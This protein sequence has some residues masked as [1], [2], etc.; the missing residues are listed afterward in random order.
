MWVH[1]VI[2]GHRHDESWELV[3]SGPVVTQRRADR[4]AGRLLPVE[5]HVSLL[6]KLQC[7]DAKACIWQKDES[8]VHRVSCFF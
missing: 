1:L 2:K 5:R 8:C 6:L 3:A 4:A 7:G